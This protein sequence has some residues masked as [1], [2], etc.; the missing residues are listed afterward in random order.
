MSDCDV[1]PCGFQLMAAADVLFCCLC[2][3]GWTIN[4][5]GSYPCRRINTAEDKLYP[6]RACVVPSSSCCFVS[7]SVKDEPRTL[8]YVFATTSG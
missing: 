5:H 1:C 7:V 2:L 6:G 8:Q 3:E 4:S